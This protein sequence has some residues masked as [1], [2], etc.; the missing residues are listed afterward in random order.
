MQFKI[1]LF[2]AALSALAYA[3]VAAEPATQ[4]AGEAAP[5]QGAGAGPRPPTNT[6]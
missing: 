4:T 5:P 3:E 2:V 1:L 6:G